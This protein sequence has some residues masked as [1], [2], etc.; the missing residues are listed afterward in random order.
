MKLFL[1]LSYAFQ[2][3]SHVYV[4]KVIFCCGA[5]AGVSG[6]RKARL[7]LLGMQATVFPVY[8]CATLNAPDP[9]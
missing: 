7:E 4:I 2:I 5:G 8:G 6:G 9:I 1:L 3:S